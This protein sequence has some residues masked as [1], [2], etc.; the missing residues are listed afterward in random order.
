MKE[1]KNKIMEKELLEIELERVN[2]K[3]DQLFFMINN[4]IDENDCSRFKDEEMR[5]ERK[6]EEANNG[7]QWHRNSKQYLEERVKFRREDWYRINET[8]SNCIREINTRVGRHCECKT[9]NPCV[10]TREL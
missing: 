6:V 7:L 4:M 8:A 2:T 3:L 10:D 5:L 1:R 9:T